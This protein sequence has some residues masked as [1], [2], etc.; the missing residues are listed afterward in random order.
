MFDVATTVISQYAA[1]PTLVRL[2]EDYQAYIDP[3]ADFDA[4]Y[5]LVW[6]VETAEGWGLDVWGRIVDI[7]RII[8]VP[9]GEITLGF[10]EA[11]PNSA[12]P[13]GF[14]AFYGGTGAT[15]SVALSD[16]AY[17]TLILAKALANITDGSI[18][19]LN[20]LLRTLFPGRGN[21]YVTDGLDMTMT[22]TFDFALEPVELAIIQQ[23]NVLAKPAGIT[24]TIVT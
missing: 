23:S 14:G 10:T 5:D 21:C 19:A 22:Y 13:F 9:S 17:R 20:L 8:Q 11:N 15:D 12:E 18:P 1:S 4:F 24:A 16:D 3:D 2:V 6:N 7:G